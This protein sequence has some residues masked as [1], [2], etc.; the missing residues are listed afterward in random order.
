MAQHYRHIAE[1]ARKRGRLGFTPGEPTAGGLL[2]DR[3][4][5]GSAAAKAGLR[6]GDVLLSIDGHAVPDLEQL[7][8]AL[9]G[10]LKGEKVALQVQRRDRELSLAATLD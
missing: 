1:L 4:R 7:R 8:R 6:Q 10:K 3:V 2:V 5:S 9:G